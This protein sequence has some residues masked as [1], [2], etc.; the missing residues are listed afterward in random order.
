MCCLAHVT[1]FCD[2][3]AYVCMCV[4]VCVGAC[5]KES[6]ELSDFSDWTVV[7]TIQLS[8]S[9]RSNKLFSSK[10]CLDWLWDPPRILF[11][12]YHEFFQQGQISVLVGVG[13]LLVVLRLRK[14]RAIPLLPLWAPWSV[15]G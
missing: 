10:T 4:C 2:L 7:W 8:N 12:G 6:R 14:S 15:L 3:C 5:E 13:Y 1:I 9:G 11:S